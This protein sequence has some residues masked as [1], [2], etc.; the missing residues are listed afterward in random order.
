MYWTLYDIAKSEQIRQ[1][2]RLDREGWWRTAETAQ[3]DGRLELDCSPFPEPELAV[4]VPRRVGQL[5]QLTG[6]G[7][8]AVGHWL[9]GQPVR[10]TDQP[11]FP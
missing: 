3:P 7:L 8:V 2:K 9:Q 4:A 6:R 10:R 1:T 11:S 5:R